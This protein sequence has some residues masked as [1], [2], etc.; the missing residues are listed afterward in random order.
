[1]GLHLRS[2]WWAAR[3]IIGKRNLVFFQAT[4]PADESSPSSALRIL[5]SHDGLHAARA[6]LSSF[7]FLSPARRADYAQRL[8]AGHH[9]VLIT[10]MYGVALSWGWVTP[11]ASSPPA[12]PWEWNV[13]LRIPAQTG[14]LWDF[15]TSFVA[16]R[17]GFYRA[18]LGHAVRACR[19]SGA[20]RVL[21]YCRRENKASRAAIGQAG[22]DEAG[23][24]TLSRVGPVYCV[25][26]QRA[27][28]LALSH[29]PIPLS[30]FLLLC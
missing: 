9:V 22:F 7:N 21:I 20:E 27:C 3:D 15:F 4:P 13:K 1:M 18:L 8:D 28:G 5:A 11:P 30:R 16:R 10:D 14:Y 2:A 25:R 26:S 23:R 19:N 17:Q 29:T 24:V 6:I 12:M